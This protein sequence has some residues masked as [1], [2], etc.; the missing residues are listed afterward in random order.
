MEALSNLTVHMK[1]NL[2]FKF[3][4]SNENNLGNFYFRSLK[5][6]Q[7]SFIVNSLKKLCIG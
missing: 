6:I 1:Y 2:I 4:E 7:I 5:F 3:V